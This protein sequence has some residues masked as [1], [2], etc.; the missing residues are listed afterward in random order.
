MN[1]I[2]G[3]YYFT[4]SNWQRTENIILA[5]FG[6]NPYFDTSLDTDSI[7]LFASATWA[8]TDR[9]NLTAG[10]RWTEDSKDFHSA[11]FDAS[12]AAQQVCA[13]PDGSQAYS[14][15]PCTAGSPAGAVTDELARSIDKTWSAVTPRAAIDFQLSDDAMIYA[16]ISKGFKSGAFD[17]RESS[18]VL[19]TMQPIEPETTLSYEIGTKAEW[20]TG[21]CAPTWRCSSTRSTTCRVPAP[22]S[23]AAPSRA[24]RWEMPKPVGRRSK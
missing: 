21:A 1:F 24:S 3:A 16:S 9:L 22:T 14:M 7:A 13:A 12:G 15:G 19:Y 17:G 2:V 4:E 20:S 8:A 23:T 18:I 10:L 6:A 11:V 5:P